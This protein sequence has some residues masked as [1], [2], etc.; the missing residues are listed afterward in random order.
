MRILSLRLILGW[1][2]EELSGLR[3]IR[4]RGWHYCQEKGKNIGLF[5]LSLSHSSSGLIISSN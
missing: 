3:L 4:L 2:S 5:S 1:K